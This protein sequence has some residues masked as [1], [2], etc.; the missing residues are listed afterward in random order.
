AIKKGIQ[1]EGFIVTSGTGSGKSLT[2]LATIFNHIFELGDNKPKG[3]KAILVYPMNALINSQ[4]IEIKKYAENFGDG[5]PVSVATYSGQN[6]NAERESIQ[7]DPPDILLT[8]YMM[9]ELIMTRQRESWLRDSLKDSLKYL[10]FDELHTYRGRQGS[11][12][13]ML[14]RRIKSICNND[15]VCIG[16]SATMASKGSV[17][18][19]K[20]AV[21]DVASTIF[22]ES[23]SEEQIINEYLEP[24]TTGQSFSKEELIKYLENDFPGVTEE[25]F[26]SSPLS[27]WLE[28]HI[29]LKQNGNTLERGVPLTMH[30][31]SE[32]L[33]S[34]TGLP[35][36]SCV[37]KVTQL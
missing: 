13:S 3:I 30:E 34:F 29:A 37:E 19:K 24:C 8:N 11:D 21:A 25:D 32:K 14:I 4:E 2:F 15:L 16:T 26:I 7:A 36:E 12:V 35:F 33:V 23:Y 1:D 28:T 6:S 17:E 10:I 9:L 27:I 5:F 20:K 18:E 31:I 22:G